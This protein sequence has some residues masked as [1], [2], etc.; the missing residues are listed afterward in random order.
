MLAIVDT[1]PILAATDPADSDHQLAVA[2]LSR[3]GVR[4]VFPQM[5]VFEAAYLIG[6]RLGAM[7][8]SRF[9]VGLGSLE[10]ESPHPTDWGRMAEIVAHYRDFPIG[11]TDASIVALAERLNID[12]IITFDQRHFRAVRPRHVETFRLLPE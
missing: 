4:L 2:A 1:G 8:E 11:A 5:V 10:I 6:T 12:L 9:L 7:A 3:P